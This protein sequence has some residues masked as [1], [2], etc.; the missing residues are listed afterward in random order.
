MS[1]QR[2]H[3]EAGLRQAGQ[4]EHERGTAQVKGR[5]DVFK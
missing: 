1:T 4:P 2:G 5:P 3:A